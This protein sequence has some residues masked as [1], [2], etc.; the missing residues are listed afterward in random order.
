MSPPGLCACTLGTAETHATHLCSCLSLQLLL[1]ACCTP[2]LCTNST[3]LLVTIWP[4]FP[5]PSPGF[6]ARVSQ[7]VSR[8]SARVFPRSCLLLRCPCFSRLSLV[9]WCL[10]FPRPSPGFLWGPCFPRPSLVSLG[11][12]FPKAVTV[13]SGARVPLGCRWFLWGSCSPR[14]L[15]VS[16]GLVFL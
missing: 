12:V 16:L 11:L 10:C 1:A 4:V 14:P 9:F 3:S 2:R 13:F 8:F 7:A 6:S 15:L 5:R